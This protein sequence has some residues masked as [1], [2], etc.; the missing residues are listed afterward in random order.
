MVRKRDDK[1][2]ATCVGLSSIGYWKRYEVW[3]DL[4]IVNR[5]WPIHLRYLPH[6]WVT[7]DRNGAKL[8]TPFNAK[9]RSSQ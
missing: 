2:W 1:D 6:K 4:D 8:K 5:K 3:N 7:Y 9:R